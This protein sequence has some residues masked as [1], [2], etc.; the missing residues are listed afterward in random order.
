[1]IEQKSERK[2]AG[3]NRKAIKQAISKVRDEASDGGSAVELQS[4]IEQACNYYL[5]H[6]CFPDTYEA[7][8]PIPV[9]KVG[10][11]PYAGDDGGERGQAYRLRIDPQGCCCYVALR[12]PD[13]AGRWSSTWTEPQMSLPL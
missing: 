3:K 2:A 8:Q 6:G 11:L 13:Q 7:M 10:I 4:L 12:A 9:L 1:M 5:T